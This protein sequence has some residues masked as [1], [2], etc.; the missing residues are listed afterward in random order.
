MIN[1][2]WLDKLSLNKT[3]T[4]IAQERSDSKSM[5]LSIDFSRTTID[6]NDC[7][8]QYYEPAP[9]DIT[10]NN[11]ATDNSIDD[12]ELESENIIESKHMTLTR[13][14]RKTM[15]KDLK[16]TMNH[17]KR[18]QQIA[19]YPPRQFLSADDQD[20]V[21]K[22]RFYLTQEKKAL[23]KFLQCVR[24]DKDEQVEQALELLKNWSNIDI[25]DALELLGPS[26][27]HQKVRS[28]AVSRLRQAPDEVRSFYPRLFLGHFHFLTGTHDIFITIGS[29]ASIRK[30]EY[31]CR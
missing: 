17:L 5:L 27:V 14:G 16:P 2:E 24:W 15:D 21:W 6:N 30:L 7:I 10:W 9:D 29:S 20:L 26:Y 3:S 25:E 28:Y 8:V 19:S 31:R 23:T 18:L 12:P 4:C 11:N 1:Q 22:Y 13:T